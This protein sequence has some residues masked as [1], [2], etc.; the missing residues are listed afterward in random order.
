MPNSNRAPAIATIWWMQTVGEGL[1]ESTGR[2]TAQAKA[3]SRKSNTSCQNSKHRSGTQQFT[4]AAVIEKGIKSQQ[5][6][7]GNLK[8]CISS[9]RKGDEWEQEYCPS[10]EWE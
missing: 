1:S 5:S 3:A 8:K 7:N 6:R 9:E 2:E 10:K 4:A